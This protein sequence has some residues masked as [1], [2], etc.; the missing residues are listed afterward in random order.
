MCR[1]Y[2][3]DPNT[4]ILC[5][6]AANADITT[7]DALNMAMDLDPSGNR[8]LGVLTKV[9]IMDSGTNIKAELTN[10]V[11]PLKR[12]YVAVKNR[13]QQDIK[14]NV[15]VQQALSKEKDWFRQHPLYRNMNYFEYFGT[16]TLIEKL[17][18]MFFEHLTTSLPNI[19][20]ELKQLIKNC[21]EELSKFGTDYILY[22]D[23][24]SKY[25][26]ITTLLTVFCDS[27]ERLFS[28]KMS[29]INEN[30]TNHKLKLIYKDFLQNYKAQISN[31]MKNEEIIK[32][33]RQTEGDRLSGFP[34][35]EVVHALLDND[36]EN[37]RNE[38]K[39]FLDTTYE[40]VNSSV[41]EIAS[42]SFCRFPIIQERIEELLHKFIEEVK[43]NL[44]YR[45]LRK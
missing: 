42:K 25:Q 34:E 13:S 19:Y 14:N 1:F 22:S 5:T 11:V 3:K 43:Y 4:I 2:C 32:I 31:N 39:I 18:V 20:L 7:S 15:T 27:I 37:L 38:V 26:Y 33:L 35:A 9:D 17:K 12:G 23:D 8:T 40:I 36:I 21:Q 45:C 41:K 29:N 28:G 30:L 16:D 6:I 44:T 10:E 24:S